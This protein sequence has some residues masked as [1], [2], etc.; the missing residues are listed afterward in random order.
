MKSYMKY[1]KLHQ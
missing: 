1:K